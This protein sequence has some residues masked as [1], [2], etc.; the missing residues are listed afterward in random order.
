MWSDYV[1]DG[2]HYN[3]TVQK[4]IEVFAGVVETLPYTENFET[5]VNCST[6]TNCEQIVCGLFNGWKNQANLDVDDIDWRTSQGSTPS[7][8]TGPDID[9]N[10]GTAAGN[11][12]YLEA[13]TCFSKE[14]LAISPCFDLNGATSP[15]LQFWYHMYGAD[16]GE[17]HVD[18]L[19]NG[20]MAE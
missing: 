1:A 19:I 16:M 4:V 8:D 6:T 14:A 15:E 11:Y 2:N 18:V 13:S 5:F 10:P 9:H 7:A 12:L 20:T 3:D 17:L